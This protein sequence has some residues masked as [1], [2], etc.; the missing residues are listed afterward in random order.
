MPK[1]AQRAWFWAHYMDH[2]SFVVRNDDPEG[3]AGSI[4]NGKHKLYCKA[5]FLQHNVKVDEDDNLDVLN[6][7]RVDART[8]HQIEAY[9]M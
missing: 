9:C 7:R 6:N 2:P 3:F 1:A 8:R 5:C 4:S